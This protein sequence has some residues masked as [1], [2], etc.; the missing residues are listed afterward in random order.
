MNIKTKHR[1]I[2]TI[3]GIICILIIINQCMFEY[4]R[5]ARNEGF[6][7]IVNL[8]FG[9]LSIAGWCSIAYCCFRVDVYETVVNML[10]AKKR[11]KRMRKR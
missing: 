3:L 1:I 9:V 2:N 7:F 6:K 8:I 4:E 10:K 11:L 5:L